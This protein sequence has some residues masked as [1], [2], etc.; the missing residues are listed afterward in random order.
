MPSVCNAV[1]LLI[2]L[3]L[4]P[5]C[6]FL[7]QLMTRNCELFTHT[8]VLQCSPSMSSHQPQTTIVFADSRIALLCHALRICVAHV[9]TESCVL[10]HFLPYFRYIQDEMQVQIVQSSL[11]R[12]LSTTMQVYRLPAARDMYSFTVHNAELATCTAQIQ[13]VLIRC[14]NIQHILW[15]LWS[16]DLPW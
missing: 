5:V 12:S 8:L 7:Q 13:A 16:I 6:T 1:G 14:A 11:N 2:L 10:P 15:Q 3:K 4:C 9:P